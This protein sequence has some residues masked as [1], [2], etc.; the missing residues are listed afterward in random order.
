MAANHLPTTSLRKFQAF[1]S[2]ELP[3]MVRLARLA[4][5]A[6]SFQL[7]FAAFKE[8]CADAPWDSSTDFWLNKFEAAD[9]LPFVPNYNNTYVAVQNRQ[10][11]YVVLHCS[12]ERPPTSVVGED[13]L[14]VKVPVQNVAALDGFSQN[15]IDVSREGY[16][17]EADC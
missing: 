6:A 9:D 3:I 13:A 15:L 5:L 11:R 8:G 14:F 2:A 12:N 7:V 10:R 4:C 1:A 16:S 17:A